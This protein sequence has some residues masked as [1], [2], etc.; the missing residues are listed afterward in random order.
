MPEKIK[1]TSGI[2]EK[3]SPDHLPG[4][5][6]MDLSCSQPQSISG[7]SG[8]GIKMINPHNGALQ[9]SLLTGL[10]EK[11][12]WSGARWIGYEDIPDS[13]LLV[14]GVHGSGDNLGNVAQEENNCSLLQKRVPSWEENFTCI[15]FCQR[16]GPV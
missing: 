15:Y 12:D 7:K 9:E 11:S 14:P 10:F 16:S 5:H 2:Q 4:F 8:Y 6:T 3:L 1:E 13:L